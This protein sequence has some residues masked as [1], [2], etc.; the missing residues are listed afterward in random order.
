MFPVIGNTQSLITYPEPVANFE[1]K[2]DLYKVSVSRNGI[3]KNSFV[4]V[5]QASVGAPKWE[6]QG[7][8][9]KSFHFTTFSFSGKVTISV[10]KV[11]SNATAATIR[12]YRVGLG[13]IATIKE[14]SGSK[15]TF[16]LNRSRKVSVEFNDD[17]QNRQVLMIFADTLEQA[18]T[19][20]VQ[21][22]ANVYTPKPADS[23]IIPAGKNVVCFG[24]GVYNIKYFRVPATVKQIYISGGAYLR[25]YILA[26][27]TGNSALKINGRGIISND[28]WAFHYP[29]VADPRISL[30][31][32]WYKSVV[33]NGGKGHVVEGIAL[34]DGS[35]F[36]LVMAADSSI[37]KNVKIH[38]FR[39]N[40]DGITIAGK[41]DTIDDCFIRVGDDGIVANGSSN[42]KI[43]NC[44][45][46]HLRGGSCIQLGW[47]PHNIN[48]NNIIQN[49]DVVH[50]EWSA[51]Q[52]QNSGFINYMG[53]IAGVAGYTIENFLVK[54]IYFDT[55]VFKVFDIRMN[56]G[57]VRTPLK[58]N[59]FVFKNIYAK[60][61]AK[62]PG[63]A[64]YLNGYDADN[65]MSGIKFD[66][67]YI[68]GNLIHQN[69]YRQQ[70]YFKVGDFVDSL[71]FN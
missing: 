68:N 5:S 22:S 65:R 43:E 71:V 29:E 59:N 53:N 45:F 11:N 16:T 13:T 66:H 40:N 30:S 41:N 7:Q 44:I 61:P 6:W 42:Y 9:G 32:G 35:A 34:I 49:C 19:I 48:G 27:R 26:N 20:P 57:A 52:T 56:R 62:L 51:P 24:P 63:Y 64:V 21:T 36:N 54:D 70:G 31:G 23:L 3:T 4:Y 58:I 60:I 10:T 39:Y 67:F 33:I 1:K 46:W 18:S 37:V 50:A 69:N 8:E 14:A 2:S 38:G 28:Q 17:P 15:V 55:E 25:G 12:P 47:R